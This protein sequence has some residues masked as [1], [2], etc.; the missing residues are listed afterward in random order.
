M[1]ADTPRS[2]SGVPGLDE[3]LHGGLIA[4]RLYLIDGEPGAGKTTLALQYLMEGVRQGERALYVTL[5]ETAGELRANAASHGWTLDDIE[6][7]ELVVDES[8]LQ[9]DAELTMY[10]AAEVELSETT[11]R[12]LAAVER[13]KPQR[14]V[15]D[16]LS[17]LRLLAQSSLR[18]RRQI[19]AL[20]QFFIGRNC[21]VLCLDDRSGEGIDTQVHS[22]AHGVIELDR[23]V[24]DYGPA[25]RQLRV[26]KLRGSNFISG[27]QDLTIR[28][29]GL[30]VFPRLTANEHGAD[31]PREV[32]PSG[33]KMLDTLLGGGIERGTST[34]LLG[35]AGSGK[36]TIAAQYAVAAARRGA[37]AAIFA[38][39]ESRSLLLDRLAK[40]GMPV[41]EGVGP[42]RL[43]VR[44]L[45][46]AEVLPSQF[47]N[48]VRESVERDGAAVIVI[49][50]LNGY[51]NA[52]PEA[53]ALTIQLHEL[54]TYLNNHGVATFLVATQS[55]MMGAG[56]RNPVDASYLADAVVLFRMYEHAGTVRKAIS[57]IKKRSGTHED[58]IRQLWFDGQGVHLGPPLAHLRGVLTGV[59]VELEP[60]PQPASGADASAG[61]AG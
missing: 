18:Y 3:V 25:L 49:D 34:L 17:E 7:V 41:D 40:L 21:T 22:I 33:V 42:G 1:S 11:R 2:A 53:R 51:M 28:R 29:G 16:S 39:E 56:T 9:G 50:S 12:V 55:G 35:P 23:T 14:M 19:L 43:M 60:P 32:V 8:E 10:H 54:L 59:P 15:L 20:K 13:C 52:M 37:H 57:V 47:V 26:T 44:Q 46:P 24:P 61:P 58:T 38:F 36:S 45:D 31:F 27:Q 30:R 4:G 6:I 48:L 5:G